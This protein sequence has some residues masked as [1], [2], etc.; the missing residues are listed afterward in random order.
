MNLSKHLISEFVKITKD[1]TKNKSETTLYGTV[2]MDGTKVRIQFDGSD[3]VTPAITT[4]DVHDGE[5]VTAIIK[6]HTAIITGNISSPAARVADVNGEAGVA[7]AVNKLSKTVSDI[8][9]TVS[10]NSDDITILQK[11]VQNLSTDYI[12]ESG[13]KDIWTYETW[14]SGKAVCW[15]RYTANG[16]NASAN[17]LDG[18]YYSQPIQVTFPVT[19]TDIPV[20][21][22]N[23]GDISRMHFVREFG[24]DAT[25]AQFVIVCNSSDQTNVNI[26]VSIYAIGKTEIKTTSE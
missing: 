1:D 11:H 2:K 7:E 19:L 17:N 26:E 3:Q 9:N 5:R 8:Q 20:V 16:I 25:K 14:N 10:D 6:N 15:G 13:T 18:L 21:S 12:I 22:V 23:G 4:A 24:S